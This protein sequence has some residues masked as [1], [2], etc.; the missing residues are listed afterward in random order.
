MVSLIVLV[1]HLHPDGQALGTFIIQRGVQTKLPIWQ[2]RKTGIALIP[3]PADEGVGENRAKIRI[4]SH[5]LADD[6]AHSGI[7]RCLQCPDGTNLLRGIVYG[8]CILGVVAEG[9]FQSV[10]HPVAIDVGIGGVGGTVPV[11]IIHTI[12]YGNKMSVFNGLVVLIGRTQENGP[13][14]TQFIIQPGGRA[15]GSIVIYTKHI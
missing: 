14:G 9:N 8:T 13:G 6:R 15:E 12:G 5:Q 4:G 10:A 3:F 2:K 1:L 7:F 11:Q